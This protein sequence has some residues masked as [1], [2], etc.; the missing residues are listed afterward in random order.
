ML[1][2][3]ALL[4]RQKCRLASAT[5]LRELFS[6]SDAEQIEIAVLHQSLSPAEFREAASHIRRKWPAAKILVVCCMTTDFLE[7]PLYDE[8]ATPGL[9]QQSLLSKIERL[10]DASA[11]V[12][13]EGKN[14]HGITVRG[15]TGNLT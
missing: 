1:V 13:T 4:D 2:R 10:A 5:C 6:I 14:W 11:S 9:S 12:T 8:R 7:D 15:R 3:D